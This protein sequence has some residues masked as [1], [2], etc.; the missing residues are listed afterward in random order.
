GAALYAY[1]PTPPSVAMSNVRV[2][3]NKA[4]GANGGAV[5]LAYRA[6]NK[7]EA[8]FDKVFFED[9]EAENGGAIYVDAIGEPSRNTINIT[10][11][12]FTNNKATASGNA[13][14]TA[15]GKNV[16]L[17]IINSLFF[18]NKNNDQAAVDFS[19]HRGSTFVL[20]STFIGNKDAFKFD[21]E[22]EPARF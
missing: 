9:N 4:E 1:G 22:V 21:V 15:S 19:N 8:T 18:E 13:I 14:A 20:N 10:N 7:A 3:S 12:T 2:K 5:F 11:S 17:N 6:D 16:R